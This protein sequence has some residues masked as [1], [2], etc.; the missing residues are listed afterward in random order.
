[1]LRYG[2]LKNYRCVLMKNNLF[3]ACACMA[4]CL[5]AQDSSKTKDLF[6]G[7][8][9]QS[10]LSETIQ[11]VVQ[12]Y[13]QPKLWNNYKYI[14]AEVS[15]SGLAF[16]LKRR[17]SFKHAKLKMEI[18]RPYSELCPIGKDPN[19]TGILDGATVRLLNSNGDIVAERTNARSFFPGGKRSFKWDDMDM[20][21]FA[22]YAFW[23]YFTLPYLLTNTRIVWSET[24]KGVLKA[25]FPD[26]IP[27]HSKTQEFI[28]G[29]SSGLLLQHNYTVD[30]FGKWAKAANV[31]IDHKTTSNGVLFT[32]TR[33]VTPRKKSG[34]PRK[35]PV[36]IRIEVH[37]LKFTN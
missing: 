12:A 6:M 32:S 7:N 33:L 35:R 24:S 10:L 8:T 23:N 9:T 2:S 1:M 5:H 21:Y 36:L 3:L 22:N 4:C 19:I 26:D 11:K 31:V 29:T 28:F 17:P 30:I 16:K 14:E 25:I 34:K 27:T 20:A 15:A 37:A 18:R 13:G